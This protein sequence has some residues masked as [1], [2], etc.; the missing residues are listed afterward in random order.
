LPSP[1]QSLIRLQLVVTPINLM[2]IVLTL[3]GSAWYAKIQLDAKSAVP[4][5]PATPL[6]VFQE[7][8]GES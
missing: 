7:A 4:K 8:K 1:S 3:A 5:P 6:L 2:G